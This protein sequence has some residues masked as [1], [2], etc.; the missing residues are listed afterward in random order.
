MSPETSIVLPTYNRAET[1]RRAIGS[2]LAQTYSEWEL[3]VVDDGSTDATPDI[4]F[5]CDPRIRVIRQENA[6][7]AAARNTGLAASRGD[8]IAFL[9]SDDEW[10]PHFLEVSIGY[11]KSSPTDDYVAC[12]F[13]SGEDGVRMIE[14]II[15]NIFLPAARTIGAHSL[16]LPDGETDDYMR[17][18]ESREPLGPW[19]EGLPSENGRRDHVYHGH[20]FRHTRWGYLSW[21]PATVLTRHALE[22]VGP[23]DPAVR[24]GEDYAFLTLL[25][26]HF[27]SNLISLPSAKKH[28]EGVDGERLHQEHLATD[29]RAYQ[30]RVNRLASFDRLHWNGNHRDRELRFVRKHYL[31][32]TACMALDEGMR[33]E[34]AQHFRQAWSFRPPFWRAFPM[35]ALA[36]FVP[37]RLMERTAWR[38]HRFEDIGG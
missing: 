38:W 15:V 6:G 2:V 3:I 33:K 10:L 9:D 36:R 22:V 11:L 14:G 24:T 1:L 20:I 4:D 21:V 13:L 28:Q 27:R 7:V 5:S 17:V 30:F 8:Y 18:W 25:A 37:H 32:H 35:W 31:Y 29:S 12:E 34:A 23:F 16:D 26:R 19:A